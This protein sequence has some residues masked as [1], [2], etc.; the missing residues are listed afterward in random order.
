MLPGLLQHAGKKTVRKFL[1]SPALLISTVK[2]QTFLFLF[3]C[4][5]ASEQLSSTTADNIV[6]FPCCCS[7]KTLGTNCLLLARSDPVSVAKR[8]WKNGSRGSPFL[9][10][11]A[12]RAFLTLENPLFRF[13]LSC[14]LPM[15]REYGTNWNRRRTV[16]T[17]WIWQGRAV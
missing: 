11:N 14:R 10:N 16:Y 5:P 2:K 13:L 3:C 12:S 6:P 15:M 8:A 1:L 4:A 9:W 17:I 7:K